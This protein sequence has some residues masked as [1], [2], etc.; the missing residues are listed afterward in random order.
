MV[1]KMAVL[2]PK[3]GITA[4]PEIRFRRVVSAT[5][6][7]FCL[8]VDTNLMSRC[9]LP[10]SIVLPNTELFV[11]L[12]KSLSKSVL[13][14][15]L[16]PYSGLSIKDIRTEET[17]VMSDITENVKISQLIKCFLHNLMIFLKQPSSYFQKI[18]ERNN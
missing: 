11:N 17:N 3:S 18:N 16:V 1:F 13:T 4:L 15:A 12:K 10:F 2:T 6:Q 7:L 14:F 8:S 9:F 5:R